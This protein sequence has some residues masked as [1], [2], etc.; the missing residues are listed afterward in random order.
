MDNVVDTVSNWADTTLLGEIVAVVVIIVVAL[1]AR[2]VW[3]RFVRRTAQALTTSHVST[4]VASSTPGIDDA[5]VTRYMARTSSAAQL[6]SAVGTFVIFA[7]AVVVL[8]A[9]VGFDVAPIL[10][11][12]GVAGLAIGFGA[13]TIIRDF[14]SGVFM[15]FENQYAIGDVVTV[16][17]VTGTVV[18]V[19]LRITQIRDV[20]GTV[21]YVTNGSVTELGNRSQGWSLATVDVPVA[22]GSDPQLVTDVLTE[23]ARSMQHSDDW[24]AVILADEPSVAAEQMTAS[25]VTYRVRLHTAPGEQLAVARALRS[26]ALTAID[27]AGIRAPMATRPTES[28]DPQQGT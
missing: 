20:E 14:L 27:K 23:V 5:A 7:V 22:Y 15:L 19:G 16:G 9:R 12:A 11:S 17:S 6:I 18:G 24:S 26:S 3:K 28:T 21:W 1:V 2:W 13:Q 25:A 4:R 8:L 10:A